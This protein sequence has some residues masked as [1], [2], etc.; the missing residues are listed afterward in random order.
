MSDLGLYG[1]MAARHMARW[2]PS[3]Y[4]AI[5]ADQRTDYFTR[6]DEEITNA[7]GDRE[8]SLKPP[9][10]LQETNFAEYVGQMNMAHLMAEEEVLAEMVY[11]PPEPGLESEAG[12]PE[13]DETGAFIDRGWKPPS[14][15]GISDE[16]WAE[17]LASG[18]WQPLRG[19][20]S[21]TGEP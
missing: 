2:Q 14:L 1:E 5:P 6:L 9:A 18:D 15:I 7:I 8:L 12:E 19:P 20:T 4:A 11:L 13:R 17:Q 21:A 3:T 16:E 10:S